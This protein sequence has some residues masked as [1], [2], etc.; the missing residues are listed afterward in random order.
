MKNQ[1]LA[2]MFSDLT[3][4]LEY[5][6]ENP[7]KLRA[8]QKAALALQNL[9]EDIE[10][11]ARQGRLQEIPGVG[12]GIA[13]KIQEYLD[14]GKMSKFEE[15]K[16]GVPEG[17]LEMMQIPGLGPKTIALVNKNL[18][19][20]TVEKLETAVRQGKLRD[21][22]GMGAKKE[23]NILRGIQMLREMLR[24]GTQR[25]PLGEAWPIVQEIVEG[26]K[27][28][29]VK[30]IMPAGSLRRMKET[31][32]DIDILATALD[33]AA[34]IQSFVKGA[35]VKEVLSAGTTKGSVIAHG[36]RQV[37]LRVVEES[38]FG[39]ALQYF[40]GSKEHNIKLR[41]IAKRRGLKVNEYGL[42]KG[43]RKVAGATEEEIYQKLGLDWIPPTLRED[44]GEIEAAAAHKLPN[45]I[46]MH[47]I[48]GDL[49]VH[50][51]WSD[52]QSTIEE[53]A[54]AAKKL[55]YQY[56]CIADHTASLR[57]FGGLS[58]DEI[59]DKLREIAQ[60]QKKLKDIRILSGV[61]VDI[62]TDG[63][64]DYSDEIL[65]QLDVVTASVHSAF[66]QDEKAMT[67]RLLRAMENPHV[68][69]I[70]HP[71][72]RLIGKREPYALD[73]EAVLKKA[74]ETGTAIE[75]NSFYDR[76]D[77]NDVNCRRAKELGVMLAINTDA[78]HA[79]H[80]QQI[81]FGV[82]T[83]Q[84]GWIEPHNVLNAMPLEDLMAWLHNRSRAHS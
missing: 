7:F 67:A 78:H 34:V 24:Q 25:I 64:L 1:E 28:A 52:G 20:D 33:G 9:S 4:L 68:D 51:D 39:A 44:R 41:D 73:I 5:K 3:K 11:V 37:D 80:L 65:A 49:H 55:G 72:G 21:L 45:L 69:I 83:A 46:E 56:I 29:G 27:A 81:R 32:G 48:R 60:V 14:T 17:V 22:P 62:K 42:F 18:G 23:Q 58:E 77:L 8:Y 76:L 61:E 38:S 16:K 36:G 66:Q 2:K 63:S 40:T 13:K 6:G 75:V 12:E 70:G 10:T 84:R 82:A 43:A 50:S 79:N 53:M 31:I 47:H 71:T 26:L 19:I 15:A 54:L 35:W 74:A 57:Y 59:P 30:H